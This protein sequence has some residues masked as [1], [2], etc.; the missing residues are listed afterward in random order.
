M[1][2]ML[3]KDADRLQTALSE[4]LSSDGVSIAP[5]VSGSAAKSIAPRPVEYAAFRPRI[6]MI[7]G[8]LA[9]IV[10]AIW[11]AMMLS[12][13]TTGMM[14]V[15]TAMCFIVGTILVIYTVLRW[16]NAESAYER[17]RTAAELWNLRYENLRSEFQRTA[18]ALSH[19]TDGVV[20]LSPKTEIVLINEAARRLLALT[21]G[22]QYLGRKI[23]EM[24]RIPEI[25]AAVDRAGRGKIDENV[26]VEVVD[27]SI[28]RPVAVRVNRILET[29]PPHLLLVLSDETEAQRVEA[30]RREFI[31]NVSHELK[32][33]LAA[34]KGYAETVELAIQDDPESA[35]HFI[36][37]IGNQCDRLEYLIAD[38]MKLA[39][40]QSG[41]GT[42]LIQSLDLEKVINHAMTSFMP[43]AGAKQ[44][45]L[46]V[47]SSD[48]PVHVLADEEAALT[49][50]Q[51]LISN[52]IRHTNAGGHVTVSCR[53]EEA[54][55]VM[56]VKDDG[57]GI[58]EE[59]QERIF[60]RFYR[61]DRTRK[62]HD[63]GTG[64]GLAI[65]KNL[66]RALGGRVGVI[67]SPGKGA[68]FEVWLRSSDSQQSLH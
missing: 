48:S 8:P 20:M 35:A 54:G 22:G 34:I 14:I 49:I 24:V 33:P 53:R 55:W 26:A 5:P 23:S 15:A 39:R 60:E 46:K 17:E 36:A 58:A 9:S 65:V 66:T 1:S 2:K 43:V 63:G 3:P 68:T 27:G 64:I 7:I 31:A 47:E 25:V 67:S 16:E 11:L 51:N 21:S 6:G 28:V 59:F 41:K 57:V 29:Q 32:T 52:A 13:Q 56:A 62:T 42:L 12:V 19:M 30:I 4:E 45:E 10:A 18:S 38:M 44:I 37:Q 40:A 61:V 50:T